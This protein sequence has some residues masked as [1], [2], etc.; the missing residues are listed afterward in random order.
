[1]VWTVF[2][3][4]TND[5]LCTEDKKRRIHLL[6]HACLISDDEP[7]PKRTKTDGGASEEDS[8]D[9]QEDGKGDPS[10]VKLP[11]KIDLGKESAIEAEVLAA[12]QRAIIPLEERMKEFRGML[13]EKEVRE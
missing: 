2:Q 7:Q 9:G 1:M 8:Q 5:A 4:I 6:L 13:A 11:E 3:I 12:R 10:G